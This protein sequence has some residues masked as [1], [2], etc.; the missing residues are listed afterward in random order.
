M[1]KILFTHSYF[2]PLDSKQW[3]FKQP[4]PPLATLLAAAVMRETKFEVTFFDVALKSDPRDIQRKLDEAHPDF[5]VIY[6]DG[7]NY[8]TKMCLTV[9]REAAFTMIELAK[10]QKATVII[11]SSDSSDH[12]EKYLQAGADYVVRGEGEETLK[13]LLLTLEKGNDV[14]SVLGIAFLKNQKVIVNPPRQVMRDLDQLPM[15][16]WDLIDVEPYRRIWK[17]HHGYFSLNMATTRGCPYKCNWC[18][19]PIY[20]NRY[21][22]RSPEHVVR[23][24]QYLLDHY[25]PDH[26]WMCDDIFG[27]KP[28]WINQFAELVRQRQLKFR[29]KIQSRVDLLSNEQTVMALAASGAETVWVGAESGSQKILDAMDKGTTQGQIRTATSLLRKHKIKIA[30]FLQFGYTGETIDDVHA[31][32]NM[33]L[34]QMPDEIGISVSYPLPGTKFY[35]NVKDQL[36]EKQNWTDSDDL[37]MLYRSTYSP[38]YYKLLHRYV[39]SR[40]RIQRGMYQLK[41]G[42]IKARAIASI[43]YHAPLSLFQEWRLN[44]LQHAS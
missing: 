12:Y 34:N 13:E 42:K 22:S 27:L 1:R 32:L 10:Q 9:M 17:K 14:Q 3:K 16:A 23:E 28:D 6:D 41:K 37:A 11:S 8:L 5:F 20:G 19:K 4:Y 35:E 24:I 2:Y 38:A 44:R 18:A 33:V 21:N 7:F 43:L 15:P 29:Y 31:T 40:Y 26:F 39:H 25:Q 36:K 30:Y